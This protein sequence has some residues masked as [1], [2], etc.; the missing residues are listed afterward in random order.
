MMGTSRI[1]LAT[2]ALLLVAGTAR[3]M[4]PGC[5]KVVA[6]MEANPGLSADEV[7]KRTDTDV[8]TVRSC[9][10]A[11]RA[12]ETDAKAPAAAA[13]SPMA[14]GCAKIVAAMQANPGLSAEEAAKQTGTDVETVRSCTRPAGH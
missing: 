11:A 13:G 9:T 7:A 10:D 2:A 12:G 4:A 1:V 5:A 6:A 8:E 3:A 14:P